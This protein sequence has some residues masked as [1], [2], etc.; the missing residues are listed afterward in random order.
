M[1]KTYKMGKTSTISIF[2]IIISV[3]CIVALFSPIVGFVIGVALIGSSIANYRKSR[4]ILD[5]TS[6]E[7][8][9]MYNTE[10]ILYK[11]IQSYKVINNTVIQIVIGNDKPKN[12]FALDKKD[13]QDIARHLK[14]VLQ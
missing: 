13:C 4:I 2:I 9:S 3:C 5:D 6:I 7:L 1:T 11:K 8:I 10:T 14:Q 12:T